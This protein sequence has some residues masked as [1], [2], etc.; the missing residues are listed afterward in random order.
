MPPGPS[1]YGEPVPEVG[2]YD[3]DGVLGLTY[4]ELSRLTVEKILGE[5]EELRS[6]W[7]VAVDVHV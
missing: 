4:A 3:W 2:F 7:I 1:P 5:F 6:Y